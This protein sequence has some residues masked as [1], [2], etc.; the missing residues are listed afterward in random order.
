MINTVCHFIEG[1]LV[2]VLVLNIVPGYKE[3]NYHI[4]IDMQYVIQIT[5]LTI[6]DSISRVK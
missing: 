5:V 1:V 3:A 6:I 4:A 2:P